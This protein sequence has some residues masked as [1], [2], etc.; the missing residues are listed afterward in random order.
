MTARVVIDTNV[1][2]DFWVFADTR[3]KALHDALLAGRVQAVRSDAT[4]AELIEV[5]AR[6]VFDSARAR[7]GN[8]L[9]ADLQRWRDQAQH[10]ARS[11]PCSLLCSD[12][13]DQKFLDL[14]ISAAVHALITKDR[15]LLKLA[16]KAKNLNLSIVA[17]EAALAALGAIGV[18]E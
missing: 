4:D 7:R 3:A 15:A 13:A 2:L 11:A 16:R 5:L 6:P 14:A 9:H 8:G 1:L 17:P 12:R 10:V 18:L